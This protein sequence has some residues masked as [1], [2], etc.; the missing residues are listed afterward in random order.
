MAEA[1]LL[2]EGEIT[3]LY[4]EYPE[5]KAKVFTENPA[6][7]VF[8]E[9]LRN[10][11]VSGE[12]DTTIGDVF[13]LDPIAW[14]QTAQAQ[15]IASLQRDTEESNA[16]LTNLLE[17]KGL[18]P[19]EVFSFEDPERMET[20][21]AIL[22]RY[23]IPSV[24]FE[25]KPFEYSKRK[26]AG[27]VPVR[28][29]KG[30]AMG[31]MDRTWHE[32]IQEK[33]R[34]IALE[35]GEPYSYWGQNAD[36]FGEMRWGTDILSEEDIS[37]QSSPLAQALFSFMTPTPRE[38]AQLVD[39]LDP[40][41][42]DGGTLE[43]RWVNS[44]DPEAGVLIKSDKYTDLNGDGKGQW[45]IWEPV[46][47]MEDLQAMGDTTFRFF[48][49]DILP[50]LAG[51][52][53]AGVL[54]HFIGKYGDKVIGDLVTRGK[55][56]AEEAI[57]KRGWLRKGARG[58]GEVGLFNSTVGLGTAL[59]HFYRLGQAQS[60]GIHPDL[61][62]ERAAT[63]IKFAGIMAGFGGAL[64]DSV[65]RLGQRAWRMGGGSA[66]PESTTK[67]LRVR[68]KL[69]EKLARDPYPGGLDLSLKEVQDTLDP[70]ARE[71]GKKYQKTWGGLSGD[72][73]IQQ[74]EEQLIKYL[75]VGERESIAIQKLYNDQGSVLTHF[76]ET[77]MREAGDAGRKTLPSIETFRAS[78]LELRRRATEKDLAEEA[79]QLA[80]LQEEAGI[81]QALGDELDPQAQREL[82]ES[83]TAREPTSNIWPEE[84][85][86][87][88]LQRD[89]NREQAEE[90][91]R[92]VLDSEDFIDLEGIPIEK[93]V[94]GPL[95]DFL[96]APDVSDIF[97]TLQDAEAAGLIK[98]IIPMR[99]G[100]SILRQLLE[101]HPRDEWGQFAEKFRPT[102][103][104][105]INMRQNL[106]VA[107]SNS[108]NQVAKGKNEAL[109]RGLDKA[110][111]DYINQAAAK[112]LR[113]SGQRAGP[114]A[115][116]AFR[117]E[118]FG[119]D[120]LNAL[121][122][123]DDVTRQA[124]SGRYLSNLVNKSDREVADFI[125]TS[126]P[127][128]ITDLFDLMHTMP[129]GLQR[130]QNVRALSLEAI[131]KK[132][133]DPEDALKENKN[134]RLFLRKYE[135]QLKA[136]FPEEEV[137]KFK[138]LSGYSK[139][140]EKSIKVSQKRL[141]SL[142][143]KLDSEDLDGERIPNFLRSFL[144]ASKNEKI[145]LRE[146]P[147]F[148]ELKTLSNMAD[149]FPILRKQMR[150]IFFTGFKRMLEGSTFL[151]RGPETRLLG[152]Q[153]HFDEL[154][155][156][157]SDP[158]SAGTK[159]TREFADDLALILGKEDAHEF[160]KNLR[161]LAA[162]LGEI[163]DRTWAV[164]GQRTN[165][166]SITGAVKESLEEGGKAIMHP[167]SPWGRK[168]TL[169]TGKAS[170]R[171]QRYLAEIFTDPAKLK[172][173]MQMRRAQMRNQDIARFL[174][175]LAMSKD[176]GG[177]LRETPEDRGAAVLWKELERRKVWTEGIEP[178]AVDPGS[179]VFELMGGWFEPD[180][181]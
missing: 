76:Y 97:I 112:S 130:V 96:N 25:E 119:S 174:G 103:K 63:D 40:L 115:V 117:N 29:G 1:A 169:I 74:T 92:E 65:M 44:K 172:V 100:D 51:T 177:E 64:G 9:R 105:L 140:A 34:R 15:Y 116:R 46:S 30:S 66:I 35:G 107:F 70:I 114:A 32:A 73:L 159:G 2:P 52:G 27:R 99:E 75:D 150:E 151:R 57:Q 50:E 95:F 23:A 38:V 45:V 147:A 134:F 157:V 49:R 16:A 121:I 13:A 175:A 122:D 54:R 20:S 78:F 87:L 106:R 56:G 133:A 127:E 86:Q 143:K 14:Q 158:Y 79:V 179:R 167:L 69:L 170:A 33:W 17:D 93:Y 160:A 80:K 31:E 145:A 72:E 126:S 171:F 165:I 5:A 36:V 144:L 77:L 181:D 176:V 180:E 67:G 129:D 18:T 62:W 154:L 22:R 84:R 104:Q 118:G 131:R 168:R 108:P 88:F 163:R 111:D 83:V 89:A 90:I 98:Q 123:L 47:M 136:L 164:T 6:F 43:T 135:D 59:V 71:I 162:E 124:I 128:N 94:S 37:D 178:Y 26:A 125:L 166:T 19:Q 81:G 149:E 11:L 68:A 60:R 156:L 146:S 7:E 53:G 24:H 155:R 41:V 101:A 85:A 138:T 55:E 12:R 48:A 161:M 137:A 82:A 113:A 28:T 3:D 141:E 153:F 110:I 148:Q 152:D 142:V 61:N 109:I 120:F 173:Y 102:F 10:T 39:H 8:K 132:V 91:L 42:K 58:A 139:A 4:Y 21:R